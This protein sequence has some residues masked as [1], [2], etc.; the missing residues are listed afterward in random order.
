MTNVRTGC[1]LLIFE[2]QGVVDIKTDVKCRR[3]LT[4]VYQIW[5]KKLISFATTK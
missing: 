4:L 3:R 1:K 2:K 5:K